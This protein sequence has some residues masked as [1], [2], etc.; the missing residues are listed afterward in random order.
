MENTPSYYE[1]SDIEIRTYMKLHG[2]I[3]N[4]WWH[5]RNE[6]RKKHNGSPPEGFDTWGDYWKQ[7]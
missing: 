5:A 1:P 3:E 7:Y 6:L 4:D 2:L